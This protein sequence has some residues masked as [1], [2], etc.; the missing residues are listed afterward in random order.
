M[1]SASRASLAQAGSGTL[2]L[3]KIASHALVLKPLNGSAELWAARLRRG[4]LPLLGYIQEDEIWLDLRTIRP[5]ELAKM[6]SAISALQ[7]FAG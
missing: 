1:K 2:P 4:T 7:T 6:I 3:E 5:E